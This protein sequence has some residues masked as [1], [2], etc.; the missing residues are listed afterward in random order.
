MKKWDGNTQ[1]IA[2]LELLDFEYLGDFIYDRYQ[3]P[4]DGQMYRPVRLGENH[5]KIK[6]IP[7]SRINS[8]RNHHDRGL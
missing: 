1:T 5:Y 3:D 6:H 7:P 4:N 2:E 8:M